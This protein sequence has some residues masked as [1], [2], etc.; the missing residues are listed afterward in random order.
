MADYGDSDRTRDV[1]LER[2]PPVLGGFDATSLFAGALVGAALGAIVGFLAKR[3]RADD[4]P[5]IRVK[6]GSI[7]FEV[8]D[9]KVFW[10]VDGNR[11]KWKL[12]GG[13]KL[14]EKYVVRVTITPGAGKPS[15][16]FYQGVKEVVVYHDGD[17]GAVQ[18]KSTGNHTK[19]TASAH[20]MDHDE[21][22][23]FVVTHP[24]NIKSVELDGE[25]IYRPEDGELEMLIYDY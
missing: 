6:G 19:L 13:Q 14:T 22:F 2:E 24:R 12:S 11:K 18:V 23:P 16:T 25:P 5:P 8:L 7:P 17:A 21:S 20:N 10:L 4:E 3:P 1:G 9:T 15:T